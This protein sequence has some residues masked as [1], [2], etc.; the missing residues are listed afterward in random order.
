MY[1]CS[2][3]CNKTEF[4]LPNKNSITGKDSTKL[5]P[6]YTED[7]LGNI[8]T[9]LAQPIPTVLGS[10]INHPFD[11]KN[12]KLA[13]LSLQSQQNYLK[14][15]ELF[16]SEFKY[17]P[18]FKQIQ[19]K[20]Q[21]NLQSEVLNNSEQFVVYSYPLNFNIP[22]RGSYY[23]DNNYPQH[24]PQPLYT[25]VNVNTILPD[26][27]NYE[28]KNEYFIPSLF[29]KTVSEKLSNF[30]NAFLYD[31]VKESFKITDNMST[32]N[33]YYN[34]LE[35]LQSF[36][37][38]KDKLQNF[39]KDKI[40]QPNLDICWG[41]VWQPYGNVLA[42]DR[43]YT[44][45][46]LRRRLIDMEV[47][48]RSPWTFESERVRTDRSGNFKGNY[49]WTDVDIEVRFDNPDFRVT[50]SDIDF[51]RLLT[52]L[53]IL[54]NPAYLIANE[55][56]KFFGGK[57]D[58]VVSFGQ[59][60]FNS[61]M[62]IYFGGGANY[63]FY[64]YCSDIY[65]ASYH[66]YAQDILG[67]RSPP[68]PYLLRPKISILAVTTKDNSSNGIYLWHGELKFYENL[69]GIGNTIIIST[70]RGQTDLNSTYDAYAT[71]IHEIAHAT[72]YEH[73]KLNFIDLGLFRSDGR[74]I[75]ETWARGV[76]YALTRTIYPNYIA[77]R[78]N[79][80]LDFYKPECLT[81][82]PG[83]TPLYTLIIR[84]LID[85]PKLVQRY[86]WTNNAVVSYKD[87]TAAFTIREI[88]DALQGAKSFD[89]WFNKNLFLNTTNTTK[90]YIKYGVSFWHP[91]FLASN[92]T[93]Y[94]KVESYCAPITN[95]SPIRY[96]RPTPPDGKMPRP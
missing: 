77:D 88:E 64:E 25:V 63:D 56:I 15:Y 13:F 69:F 57:T 53:G 73:D 30:E 70:N 28:V 49:Y 82:L 89:H 76:Q 75:Q 79:K 55:I 67:L 81:E 50:N 2:I 86:T 10:E 37:E 42:A 78:Y 52:G 84:D 66:Y 20:P 7:E 54:V 68:K 62:N 39:T 74:L 33:K 51:D 5:L 72:H 6:Y 1:V 60:K 9:N 31:L 80:L 83:T 4:L 16:L 71:T 44:T 93:P 14:K 40:N 26:T 35:N 32:F 18:N 87:Q 85:T 48:I 46:K 41:C 22:F 96:P 17:K 45:G 43:G 91:S 65:R 34:S 38:N 58:N 8:T 59:N 47:K 90:E 19:F 11:I 94:D 21:T 36:S 92:T 3:S 24:L 23:F 95:P 29:N 27:I 61:A 12:I